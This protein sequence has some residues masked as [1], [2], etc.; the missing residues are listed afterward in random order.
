MSHPVSLNVASS[1]DR[2]NLR[3]T[4]APITTRKSQWQAQLDRT[5]TP[6]FLDGEST[7]HVVPAYLEFDLFPSSDATWRQYARS[8]KRQRH[9]RFMFLRKSGKQTVWTA[10]PL[11]AAAT[12]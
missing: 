11:D 10:S 6:P 7:P 1:F 12:D 2:I 9:V 3:S 5:L 4:A 8:R